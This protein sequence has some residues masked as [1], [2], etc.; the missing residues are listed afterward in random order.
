MLDSF[1]H[2]MKGIAFGIVI[3]I[4]IVFAF[5]GIGSLNVSG[6][7]V[8][9]AVEV[10]G[11]PVSE[12]AIQQAINTEKQRILNQNE[13][14]DPALLEDDLIR[15]QVVEQIIG[16]KLLAQAAQNGGMAIS[17]R[18]TSKLL[19][20]TPAF[21]TDGRFDQELYLYKIR[22]Q[23][24]T[25]GTFLEMIKEDMVIEQYVRGFATSSFITPN[26][27]VQLAALTEQQ[28]DYY[29]LTLPI[30]PIEGAVVLTDEQVQSYYD[31]N[32]DRF[33]AEEQVVVEYIELDRGLFIQTNEVSEEQIKARFDEQVDALEST[34]SRQ[35]AH[36]LLTEPSDALLAEIKSKLDAG[37]DFSALAK[38]YSE[39]VG[40]ADFGGDLGYTSGDTFPEAF[41]DA[42]AALALGQVSAPVKTDSGTHLIKLLDIQEQKVDFESE[43]QRIRDQLLAEQSGEWMA[44]K[45]A[46]LK[47]LSFNAEN[48]TEV[49]TDLGLTAQVSEPF[50]RDGG[51]GIAAYPSVVE[52]A[53]GGDVLKDNYAS[54]VLD[55]GDDRYLVLKM[56]NYIPARQK[57]L[58]E[59]KSL[60]T[61]T[62]KGETARAEIAAQGAALVA[63]IK[64]GES[65][66]AVAK[67]QK[68]DWQVVMDATRS[69]GGNNP[70]VARFVFTLS[71]SSAGGVESFYTRSGDF[72]AVRLTEV[73]L[74]DATKLNSEQQASL[75]YLGASSSTSRELQG[76]QSS[77]QANADI[78]R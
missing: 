71:A 8:E 2:N 67:S 7:A 50:T 34:I 27:F 64:A 63:R 10:N 12:F 17:S 74:G 24:Y 65:V 48:L 32:K 35:A 30:Q 62:L 19:L 4:A 20:A 59:V 29:Y 9:T 69:A 33:Q 42:L 22:N 58:Q 76:L 73:T 28:R 66:E 16:R 75:A 70:E 21:L 14:L 11:E 38:T 25:N 39:D 56:K 40:S 13:G 54:N 61:D 52:A 44:E 47:E 53:F 41:E 3:L 68:L 1:R 57:E 78:V 45:L 43:R 72:V 15:P 37:D 26:E 6:T 5:S 18:A 60:I 49:A 51:N 36:I 55:L 77:L 31:A 23:G 46:K